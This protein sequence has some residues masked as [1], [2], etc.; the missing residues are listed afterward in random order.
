M[1]K[2]SLFIKYNLLFFVCLFVGLLFVFDFVFYIAHDIINLSRSKS[3][4]LISLPSFKVHIASMPNKR[5]QL[6][7]SENRYEKMHLTYTL[8]AYYSQR[9]SRNHY[10]RTVHCRYIICFQ[11]G[12]RGALTIVYA[13]SL[14]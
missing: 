5:R 1:P 2:R 8:V 12:E 4:S 7:S 3:L 10:N 6:M 14:P 9:L 13:S 11:I